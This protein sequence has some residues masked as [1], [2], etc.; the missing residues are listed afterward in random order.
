MSSTAKP[1]RLR[2]PSV[3]YWNRSWMRWPENGP[4]SAVSRTHAGPPVPPETPVMPLPRFCPFGSVL[5]DASVR[6]GTQWAPAS[7]EAST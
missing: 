1:P 5:V 6:S 2:L 7:V 4:R 3:T